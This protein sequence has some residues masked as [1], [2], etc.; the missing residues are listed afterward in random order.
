MTRAK[1]G[2]AFGGK[3]WTPNPDH[4]MVPSTEQQ[5]AELYDFPSVDLMRT[6]LLMTDVEI[7]DAVDQDLLGLMDKRFVCDEFKELTP[8]MGRVAR[9]GEVMLR[10]TNLGGQY[11]LEPWI[12]PS[13]FM[14]FLGKGRDDGV[15]M[16]QFS[17]CES[18]GPEEGNA[19][20]RRHWESWLTEDHIKQLAETGIDTVRIPVGDWQFL[21]Y[22]PYVGCTDG[23][24]EH[25]LKVLDWC[26]QHQL[27]VLI[28][29]HAVRNSQNGFD[30]S[31]QGQNVTWVDNE[32]FVHWDVRS[33]SWIGNFHKDAQRYTTF[34]FDSFQHSLQ[35]FSNM[36][37]LLFDHP[38]VV[39]FQPVNEPWQY[40]PPNA[41]QLFVWTCYNMVQLKDINLG[42]IVHDSFRGSNL[43]F[44]KWMVGCQNVMI[45]DHIYTAWQGG[46]EDDYVD[47]ACSQAH[48][49]SSSVS[50]I[51]RVV[52][53]WSLATDNCA[54]WLNGF[55]DNL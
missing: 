14:Q 35:A 40:T 32:H 8:K 15:G 24:N 48:L 4:G 7:L 18:L 1:G 5:L 12:T 37:D 22:E 9:A 50:Q 19:Q 36:V 33:A 43:V 45:D 29:L 11:V 17:F 39:A 25:L 2:T 30:N 44:N 53:E 47:S 3:S 49:L 23:A 6:W 21:P 28:D 55:N 26:T 31:G 27:S 41:Y 52:G 16:D 46:E 34:D 38:A 51:P 42:V 54:M 13:M 10:G 20:L